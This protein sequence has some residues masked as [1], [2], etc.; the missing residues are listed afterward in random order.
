MKKIKEKLDF[1][2]R[3][4]TLVQEMGHQSLR[5]TILYFKQRIPSLKH[6]FICFYET[7]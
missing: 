2:K 5:V 6:T 1:M 3:D 4:H 7:L